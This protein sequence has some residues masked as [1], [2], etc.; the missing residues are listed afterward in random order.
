MSANT[1]TAEETRK[2]IEQFYKDCLK[3]WKNEKKHHQDRY[4]NQIDPIKL[5]I[6]D[7][8]LLKSNPYVPSYQALDSQTVHKWKK[9]I[10]KVHGH[11]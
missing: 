7:V 11:E 1:L 8:L 9:S 3:F 5:A 6:R 2:I 10:Q 4:K